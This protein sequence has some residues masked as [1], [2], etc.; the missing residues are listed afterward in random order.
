MKHSLTKAGYSVTVALACTLLAF[1]AVTF[2]VSLTASLTPAFSPTNTLSHYTKSDMLHI[3]A[4][5]LCQSLVSTVIALAVGLPA[6]YFISQRSWWGKKILLSFSAVPLCMPTL[7]TAIAY[8]SFFGIN[9]YINRLLPQPL[10]FLYS[11]AGIVFTQGFYNFPL[12]MI[13]VASAWARI[14]LSQKESAL[15]LGAKPFRI[16]RTITIH[17]LLPSIVSSCVPIFLFCFFSFMIVLLFGAKGSTTF[18]V[19][20]YQA[21]RAQL[22]FTNAARFALLETATALVILFVW[23][24]ME[25]RTKHTTGLSLKHEREQSSLTA[26][27]YIFFIPLML[28]ITICFVCPFASLFISSFKAVK[29][30]VLSQ[31]FYRSLFNT[32]SIGVRTASCCTLCAF[33]YCMLCTLRQRKQKGTSL[34]SLIPLLPMAVSSVVLGIGIMKTL[35]QATETSLCFCQVALMWPF[36]FRQ[37]YSAVETIPQNIT[38][39]ALLLSPSRLDCIFRIY[40]PLCKNKLY[41]AFTLSLALSAGDATLPL[42]L[43]L[44][45]SSTLA[46]YVYRLAAS[47]RFE[48]ASAAGLLLG[49]LCMTL[50]AL[51]FTTSSKGGNA[52]VL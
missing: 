14:D 46:L 45:K 32:L 1:V 51:T 2:I 50:C 34:Q 38:D 12:V 24:W 10:T 28:V 47:Y 3:M 9:G 15:L 35:H 43:N 22:D 26:K 23:S 44:P 36:A 25:E 31:D 13:S 39:S 49:I 4:F 48:Q 7:I 37:I 18:E 17:Q 19:A 52:H 29:T 16:F 42:L 41:S 27:D 40:L 5:T 11:F 8:I 30:L 6:A 20:I 21:G 33:T